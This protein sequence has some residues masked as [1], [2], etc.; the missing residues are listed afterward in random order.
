MSATHAGARQGSAEIA[1]AIA[2]VRQETLRHI[3]AI[4]MVACLLWQFIVPL[5]DTGS[6]GSLQGLLQHWTLFVIACGSLGATYL[7]L[8]RRSALAGPALMACSTVTCTAAIWLL[9]APSG[10]F[11]YPLIV[12]AAAALVTPLSSGLLAA[13]AILT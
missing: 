10:A 11:L 8:Q 12:L 3:L 13:A 5:F 1:D 2:A 9:Q 6:V 4:L 7:L